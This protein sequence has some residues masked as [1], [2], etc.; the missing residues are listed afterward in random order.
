LAR[1]AEGQAL[2]FDCARPSHRMTPAGV[3]KS[4]SHRRKLDILI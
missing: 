4:D 3:S 2:V 1:E